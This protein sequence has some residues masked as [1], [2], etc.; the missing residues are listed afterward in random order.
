MFLPQYHSRCKFIQTPDWGLL[1]HIFNLQNLKFG[2]ET[3]SPS[4]DATWRSEI[5]DCVLSP[6]AY[7]HYIIHQLHLFLA[8]LLTYVNKICLI[9]QYSSIFVQYLEQRSRIDQH[10]QSTPHIKSWQP[11]KSH[12]ILQQRYHCHGNLQN[13]NTT[14]KQ[15]RKT[16]LIFFIPHVTS[17]WKWP[18][19]RRST[20]EFFIHHPSVLHFSYRG[21][22]RRKLTA[23]RC[24]P[25]PVY[26]SFH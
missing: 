10:Q 14:N 17:S 12:T 24:F 11:N 16:K 26:R 20:F 23:S 5:S 4:N 21:R 3:P 25:Y 1:L 13:I 9:D 2:L 18:A 7:L 8:D 19:K 22:F 6:Q 15:Q